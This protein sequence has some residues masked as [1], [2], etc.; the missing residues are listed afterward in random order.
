MNSLY[1][2]NITEKTKLNHFISSCYTRKLKYWY[3]Y[4][5]VK[6][7][8]FELIKNLKCTKLES[9]CI[10]YNGNAH[11]LFVT[12]R[13]FSQIYNVLN[14]V[15]IFKTY[16]Y[17]IQFS[18]KDVTAGCYKFCRLCNERLVYVCNNMV[19]YW[20]TIPLLWKISH[21]HLIT[22]NAP[23]IT[24]YQLCRKCI[25]LLILVCKLLFELWRMSSNSW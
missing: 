8:N 2:K 25:Y 24:Y 15:K 18:L 16:Q 19:K 7:G 20:N 9:K 11:P 12:S 22:S 5:N 17:I 14:I 3:V 13:D 23:I 4:I 10:T 21:W 1:F 6:V